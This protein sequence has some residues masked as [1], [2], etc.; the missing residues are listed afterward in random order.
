MG[1]HIDEALLHSK[2]WCVRL[3]LDAIGNKERSRAYIDRRVK[4]K[5]SRQKVDRLLNAMVRMEIV[6]CWRPVHRTGPH[7]K[8]RINPPVHTKEGRLHTITYSAGPSSIKWA[9]DKVVAQVAEELS[10]SSLE[11]RKTEA[12]E[13]TTQLLSAMSELRNKQLGLVLRLR[14]GI[15]LN[16]VQYTFRQIARLFKA[17]P[18]WVAY[19]QSC[20]LRL[21]RENGAGE[22]VASFPSLESIP[23]DQTRSAKSPPRNRIKKVVNGQVP[24]VRWYPQAEQKPYEPWAEHCRQK[25]SVLRRC[26]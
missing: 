14:F 1:K 7:P 10:V 9:G 25:T 20:A 4:G 15:G 21:L 24:I 22:V 12:A 8:G 18:Q 2:Y 11:V 19:L 17:T 6:F 23:D 5:L 13:C 26:P 3:I 16:G